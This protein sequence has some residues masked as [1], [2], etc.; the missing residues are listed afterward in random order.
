[1]LVINKDSRRL[2][3]EAIDRLG[4]VVRDEMSAGEHLLHENVEQR[5]DRGHRA[6]R[7]SN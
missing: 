1:L 3:Q 7:I 4:T 2:S 6:L 5:R